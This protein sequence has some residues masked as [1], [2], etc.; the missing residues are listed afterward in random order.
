MNNDGWGQVGAGQDDY[1]VAGKDLQHYRQQRTAD[2]MHVPVRKVRQQSQGGGPMKEHM[3]HHEHHKHHGHH[4]GH[5]HK[6]DLHHHLETE[7][8]QHEH[9]KKHAHHHLER[10]HSRHHDSQHGHDHHHHHYGR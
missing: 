9:A 1:R 4:E 7:K 6:S 3:E 10:H 2:E 5:M 8:H